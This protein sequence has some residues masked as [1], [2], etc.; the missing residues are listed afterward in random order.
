MLKNILLVA[1]GGACGSIARHLLG[2]MI[3]SIC[4]SDLPLGTLVANVLGCFIIGCITQWAGSHIGMSPAT[5]LM[6]TTGFCG[7]LTTF[8]TFM[9]ESSTMMHGEQLFTSIAY[10][11][12]SI[13]LGLAAV[14]LGMQVA[15]ML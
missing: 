7:G 2:I 13:V 12:V 15:K 5:K 6:L 11:A 10:I 1:V 9:N 14:A 8:S 3:K 4:K